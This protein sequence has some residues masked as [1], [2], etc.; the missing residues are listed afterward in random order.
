MGA[1]LLAL[2]WLLAA[3][4]GLGPGLEGPPWDA[5]GER[6][7]A[8][9]VCVL[10]DESL[11]PERA[12]NVMAAVSQALAPHGV[13]LTVPWYRPWPRAAFAQE[14]LTRDVALRPLEPPCDRLL[15]LVGRDARDFLW[16]LLLP[17]VLG[18]VERRT[19]TKGYAVARMGSLNQVLSFNRPETTAFHEV[20]HMLGC[21]HGDAGADCA[22]RIQALAAEA[23]ANR[24]AGREFFPAV[25]AGGR[26][27]ATREEVERRFPDRRTAGTCATEPGTC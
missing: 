26:I 13:A 19:H 3:G 4:C 25:T 12:E 23:R 11:P 14:G 27:L 20:L 9:R 7:E 2:G 21:A 24:A 8:L 16:G 6:P 17:E 22:R 5:A 15:A 18:A 10:R 1:V